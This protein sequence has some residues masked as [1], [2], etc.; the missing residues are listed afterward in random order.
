MLKVELRALEREDIALD[1][2]G[3]A[4]VL[5]IDLTPDL[6]VHPL[7]IHCDLSKNLDL[8][9]AKGWVAGKMSLPCARCLKSFERPYKSFFEI[10]YRKKPEAMAEETDLEFSADEVE[11]V[12]FDGETL[13]IGE[14]VRQTILLSVPMRVLCRED[15]RGLC[16][17][18]GVDLNV[19]TCR[20][21]EPPSDSRWEALKKVKI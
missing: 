7:E 14:Q 21:G 8:I 11:T 3:T 2:T 1:V 4:K 12:Y 16:G 9:L 15:C 5:G 6:S 10:H 20:C 17:G 19:E 13:D 18:C